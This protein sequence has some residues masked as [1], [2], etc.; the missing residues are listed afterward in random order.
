MI[1]AYTQR[2]SLSCATHVLHVLGVDA[3][4]RDPINDTL[5]FIGGV[6]SSLNNE[7]V[8]AYSESSTMPI[9]SR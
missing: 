8:G 4:Y 6:N 3:Q 1:Y 2:L 9:R 5:N 7:K